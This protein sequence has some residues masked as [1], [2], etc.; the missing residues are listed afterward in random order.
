MTAV[1]L[2]AD[3]LPAQT[4]PEDAVDG[5]CCVLGTIEATIDRAHA[6]KPSFTNLDVLRA[7]DS[8]RVSVRAW[9]VLT[10]TQQRKSSWICD[11]S[12]FKKLDRLGVRA[13]VIGGVSNAAPWAGYATTSYKKHGAL[14][15]PVNVGISQRWLF[16]TVIVDCSNQDMVAEWWTIL[17][18]T[19]IAGIPR[20]VIESLDINVS[21]FTKHAERWQAFERWARP[22][23]SSPLYLFL[24]YLLPSEEEIKAAR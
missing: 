16:E 21:L 4:P 24:T 20:P 9:R 7:P 18:D 1:E 13:A 12:G 23:A 5:V 11:A 14:R 6:I 3:A 17:R 22:R 15:A 2:L 8:D 10:E 19:R